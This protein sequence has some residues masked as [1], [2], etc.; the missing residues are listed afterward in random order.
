MAVALADSLKVRTAMELEQAMLERAIAMSLGLEASAVAG[1]ASTAAPAPEPTSPTAA[2]S[3]PLPPGSKPAA[4]ESKALG[5]HDTEGVGTPAKQGGDRGR[6]QDKITEP[7]TPLRAVPET[8]DGRV[9]AR[10]EEPASPGP[11]AAAAVASSQPAAPEPQSLRGFVPGAVPMVASTPPKLVPLKSIRSGTGYRGAGFN[12]SESSAALDPVKL[13]FHQ[14][15]VAARLESMKSRANEV[16]DLERARQDDFVRKHRECLL[17]MQR[18]QREQ[19]M[20]E[21]V[22]KQNVAGQDGDDSEARRAKFFAEMAAKM[23][24]DIARQE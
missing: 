18:M 2:P 14:D 15:C 5:E 20:E 7:P 10:R 4:P 23:R 11:S 24:K 12:S 8:P 1:E 9:A 13:K 3:A 22:S 19:E 6:P 16:D 21:Y 17:E